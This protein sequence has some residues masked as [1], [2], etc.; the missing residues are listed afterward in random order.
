LVFCQDSHRSFLLWPDWSR[1]SVS[2]WFVTSIAPNRPTASVVPTNPE[3]GVARTFPTY[4]ASVPTVNP[5]AHEEYLLGR[6]LLWKFIEEDRLRAIE[7][8]HRAIS[9]APDYAAPYAGL[10][11]A[12]WMRGVLG[13]LSLKEVASPARDAAREALARDDRLAEAY[14]AQAY[15]QGMFDWDWAGAEATIQRAVRIEPNSVDAHYV[16][17]ILLMAMGRLSEALA[18]IEQAAQLDPLSAHVQSTFGRILYRARRF[19]EAMERL[20]HAIELEPRNAVSV[21]RL[22]DVYLQ[23]AR[24]DE[25]LQTFD[26]ARALTSTPATSYRA[27]IA[28]TYARMGRADDARRL[29]PNLQSPAGGP[30]AVHTALGDFDAAFT[31]LFRAV[32]EREDWFLF[33][34]ADPDFDALHAD[35]RWN[36]LLQRMRLASK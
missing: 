24:Y 8:F 19:D 25:T 27:R 34:K 21:G 6:Y 23:M 18:R 4:V 5:R 30:A 22:A 11:H 36:E 33:I 28:L 16:Y 14:A 9:I 26:K 32:E 15:V 3:A 12:W 10:A 17:A 29:L 1:L 2:I 7:H 20:N 31:L 35:H 13:P